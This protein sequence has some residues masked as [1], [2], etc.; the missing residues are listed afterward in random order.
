MI[1]LERGFAVEFFK[2]IFAAFSTASQVPSC[3]IILERGQTSPQMIVQK[4]ATHTSRLINN[5]MGRRKN[6]FFGF[7]FSCPI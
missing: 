2:C 6:M 7:E 5:T 1:F 3:S 4:E